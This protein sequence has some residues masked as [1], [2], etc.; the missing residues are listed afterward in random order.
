M[1]MRHL[2]WKDGMT[3]KPLIQAILIGIV[4]IYV[5]FALTLTWMGPGGEAS[6]YVSIWVLMPNLVA[7]G[8]PA[9]L[10]GSEEEN[11]T[12]G[13][14]RTLPIRWQTVA[15]SKCLVG[16][17]A[18]AIAWIA[19]S[20]CLLLVI[21]GL[22]SSITPYAESML[23]VSGIAFLIFFSLLL[24]LCGFITAYLFRSPI[25][26]LIA[27]A[28]LIGLISIGASE[29]GRW[30]LSGDMRYKGEIQVA[31]NASYIPVVAA[32]LVLLWVVWCVQRLLAYR[33]LTSPAANAV[34]KLVEVPAQSAYR[35]PALV[36]THRPNQM[37]ALLWQQ[38]RQM[39]IYALVL[40]LMAAGFI[41]L[42]EMQ[43]QSY[44]MRTNRFVQDNNVLLFLRDLSPLLIALGA[45]W[46]GGLAFY[47]DNV[48]RRCAFFADRG[49]SPPKI[50]LTRIIIPVLCGLTLV[51][52]A[53]LVGLGDPTRRPTIACVIIV[54]LSFGQL[55]SQWSQRPVMTFLAAPA[56]TVI[57][58]SVMFIVMELYSTYQWTTVLV[59]PVLLFASWRLC[60]RWLDGRI[61]G[62][63]NGKVLGYTA[64]AVALPIL[65]VMGS[66]Y[67]ST[68]EPM[69]QWRNQMLAINITDNADRQIL[70]GIDLR[71][72][73]PDV[74][75]RGGFAFEFQSL[76]R[77]AQIQ[78]LQEELESDHLGEVVS[79]DDIHQLLHTSPIQEPELHFAALS[80]LLKWDNLVRQNVIN[81]KYTLRELEQIAERAE[82]EAV[83]ALERVP[84][85]AMDS[86]L[87]RLLDSIPDR[88][89]RSQSRRN[90]LIT[91]WK[92]Y[93]QMPWT[94]EQ[95]DRTYYGKYLMSDSVAGGV[96]WIPLERTRSDRF[97]DKAIRLTL[98]QLDGHLPETPDSPEF[99]E[100]VRLW[101][102]ALSPAS[103]FRVRPT[104]RFGQYWTESYERRIDTLRKRYAS[105]ER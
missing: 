22:V 87:L 38:W 104:I 25:A 61:D 37:R 57:A 69:P 7:L 28:P 103:S 84:P 6:L 82:W 85:S 50:W 86:E 59:A 47:G 9:M 17:G 89:L 8:A 43:P 34:N 40:T 10:V 19:S 42:R 54:M 48:R 91:L 80:V 68:P 65:V 29:V 3:I 60:D 32:G 53:L 51:T 11:G 55:V 35:P 27:V 62:G 81:G 75:S 20:L 39:G 46:I 88:E 90:G 52:I 76:T 2:L 71:G 102:E 66:R 78:R 73:S 33:R 74:Y 98:E 100:R 1:M 36:G 31:N 4:A 56:Y 5:I 79:L 23:N 16:L 14:L 77:E 72:I 63:Y 101:E 44:N 49:V 21:A 70:N 41:L 94:Y 12:L 30:I 13:W 96:A 58:T 97:V 92:M 15:D 99:A 67:V 93:D 105:I 64:L 95:G 18:V 24:L 26:G 83:G 45:S